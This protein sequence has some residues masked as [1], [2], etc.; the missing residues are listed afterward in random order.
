VPY[1]EALHIFKC[2]KGT[3]NLP[4]SMIIL[5]FAHRV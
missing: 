1:S 5:N 2:S 4:D 3:N